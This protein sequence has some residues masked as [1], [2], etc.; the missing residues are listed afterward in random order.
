MLNAM[1]PY[2]LLGYVVAGILSV[3]VSRDWVE[4]HLGGE[5]IKPVVMSALMGMPLPLCSS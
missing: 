3:L 1:A 4:R 5:G 2:L